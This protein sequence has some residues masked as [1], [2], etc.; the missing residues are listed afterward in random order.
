MAAR[1]T[2]NEPIASTNTIHATGSLFLILVLTCSR[3]LGKC[4]VCIGSPTEKRVGRPVQLMAVSRHIPRI[5]L[6]LL[7]RNH[8]RFSPVVLRQIKSIRI[9]K[10]SFIPELTDASWSRSSTAL[11]DELPRASRHKMALILLTA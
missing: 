2:A 5:K 3:L 7:L 11:C 4:S 9:N 1:S 8:K 6:R 10:P